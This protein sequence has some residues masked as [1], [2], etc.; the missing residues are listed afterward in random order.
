[1]TDLNVLFDRTTE[2]NTIDGTK[3]QGI[4]GYIKWV[5]EEHNSEHLEAIKKLRNRIITLEQ[6]VN[7]IEKEL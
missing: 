3:C 1:M 6:K 4:Y 2:I 5:I 7:D